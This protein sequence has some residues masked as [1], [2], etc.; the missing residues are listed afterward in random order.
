MSTPFAAYARQ[1]C[2]AVKEGRLSIP[3]AR[4]GAAEFLQA[5]AESIQDWLVPFKPTYAAQ[6]CP[7]R[8]RRDHSEDRFV[9]SRDLVERMQASTVW[10]S[11][12]RDVA[13]TADSAPTAVE[14]RAEAPATPAADAVEESR[15]KPDATKG[16]ARGPDSLGLV[17][18]PIAIVTASMVDPIAIVTAHTRLPS[19]SLPLSA[20]TPVLASPTK[21]G[22]RCSSLRR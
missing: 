3:E 10:R 17:V 7:Y 11:F 5:R 2:L 22:P 15:T 4:D 18:D 14:R 9:F 6:R 16:S 19:S 1:A 8:F 13:A 21:C 12:L 20:T